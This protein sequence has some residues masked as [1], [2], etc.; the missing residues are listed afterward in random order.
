MRSAAARCESIFA[1]PG[2]ESPERPRSS[3][4]QPDRVWVIAHRVCA[5]LSFVGFRSHGIA[6]VGHTHTSMKAPMCT[7]MRGSALR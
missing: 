2:N 7:A 1:N 5:H 4:P 6:S 3:L